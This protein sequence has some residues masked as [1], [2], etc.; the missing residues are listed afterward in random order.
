[1]QKKNRRKRI[2]TIAKESVDAYR[3]RKQLILSL[4][5]LLLIGGVIYTYLM[6]RV[7]LGNKTEV[8]QVITSKSALL[9]LEDSLSLTNKQLLQLN[10]QVEEQLRAE[11]SELRPINENGANKVSKT[12]KQLIIRKIEAILKIFENST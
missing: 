12:N 5:S 7:T 3:N 2:I 6:A 9:Q 4:A 8:K 1:M 11:R 10:T